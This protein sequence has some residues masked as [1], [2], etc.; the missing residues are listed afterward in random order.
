M[1]A[2]IVGFAVVLT[3]L[4]GFSKVTIDDSVLTFHVESGSETY[5]QAIGADIVKV[6]KTGAGTGVLTVASPDFKG[7]TSVEGGILQLN[8]SGIVGNGDKISVSRQA[9]LKLNF[10]LQNV[11]VS[12]TVEIAGD[13]PDGKGA[14][15]VAGSNSSD[16]L[17]SSVKLTEGATIGGTLRYGIKRLDLN[18]C[19]FTNALANQLIFNGTE[20]VNPG[21]IVHNGGNSITLMSNSS[22]FA[23]DASNVLKPINSSAAISLWQ[24][25]E[26]VV[27]W[28]LDLRDYPGASYS[29]KAYGNRVPA[30]TKAVWTGPVL[31]GSTV[32]NFASAFNGT[33]AYPNVAGSITGA[34]GSVEQSNVLNTTLA[35]DIHAFAVLNPALGSLTV[36]GGV[37]HTY[38]RIIPDKRNGNGSNDRNRTLRFVDAAA[39]TVTNAYENKSTDY[40]VNVRS[41]M[42]L[43]DLPS[44]LEFDGKTFVTNVNRMKFYAGFRT[45]RWG[46]VKISNGASVTNVNLL[47]G[48]D[49]GFGALYVRDANFHSNAGAGYD[50]FIGG[51]QMD[52]GGNSYG[53]WGMSNSTVLVDGYTTAALSRGT[54]AF[55]V[56]HGGL[57]RYNGSAFRFGHGGYAHYRVDHGG[58]FSHAA[59]DFQLGNYYAA[60]ASHGAGG[61]AVMTVADGAF[62]EVRT[63]T[64]HTRENGV[65]QLNLNGG[66]RFRQTA[67]S[68]S[69]S[70]GLFAETPSGSV[71]NLS[72]DGGIY[73]LSWNGNAF[74]DTNGTYVGI[75]TRTVVHDGGALID[76]EAGKSASWNSPLLAPAGKIVKAI[77][78]PTDPEFLASTNI[79]PVRVEIADDTGVS[80]SAFIAFDDDKGKLDRVV[81]DSP[82]TG[83]SAS[84]TATAI[85]PGTSKGYPCAVTLADAV[86]GGL[87]KLGAGDLYMKMVNTYAGATIV[88]NGMMRLDVQGAIPSGRPLAVEAGATLF[89]QGFNVEASSF[90]GSGKVMGGG[91]LSIGSLM[92]RTADAVTNGCARIASR[93]SLERVDFANVDFAALGERKD[94]KVCE[95]GD[96]AVLT[97]APEF[98]N[99]PDNWGARLA[100]DGRSITARQKFGL[101]II[102]R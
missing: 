55:L 81:I 41:R 75:P 60:W 19:T 66:G 46:V 7:E 74:R 77:A 80:A 100:K 70:G 48:V 21:N 5:D 89:L 84:T 91:T 73:V 18:S 71:F 79:G 12:G 96:A 90:S 64:V 2:K 97:A 102:V 87:V 33:L 34:G 51:V 76:V 37:S 58:T 88:S 16:S 92:P 59:A 56:Q 26:T 50:G 68:G 45:N 8:A 38:A 36:T 3:A 30:D 28:T 94:F 54:T 65:A 39:V 78:M 83:Y 32:L 93:L 15:Y 95:F 11:T 14:V 29:Y 67:T 23:G 82:G 43:G 22:A 47:T 31:L 25:G 44:R 57:H 62:A 27:P 10:N 24:C 42:D 61:T 20:V 40:I 69:P 72:F 9:Q 52:K 101:A 85:L 63:M 86:G 98:L 53:Y 35:G 49:S 1:N 99:L 17:F 4:Q 6:V 13:G